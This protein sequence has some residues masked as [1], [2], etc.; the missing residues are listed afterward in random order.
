MVKG[1]VL[2]GAS[3]ISLVA[4]VVL[5]GCSDS[6]NGNG[7]GGGGLPTQATYRVTVTN[8][9]ANQPLSPLAVVIHKGGYS[10]W[11][12]GEPVSMGL[13]VLAEE[14][15]PADFIAEAGMDGSVV[16]TSSGDGAVG[17]GSSDTVEVTGTHSQDL[18]LTTAT[19]LVNTNDAFT[20]VNE[21][22]IGSLGVNESLTLYTLPFDAGTEVNSETAVTIPGPAGGG[23]GY[24]PER[25]DADFVSIHGGAVTQD[26]GL[27]ASILDE[28]HRFIGPVSKIV[29][30]RIN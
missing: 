17:P 2:K 6:S 5:T 23:E 1:Y 7:N 26:D 18:R 10:G 25:L 15:D 13:E 3:I 14:G 29:V 20:G 28:S 12:S 24:N 21:E 16:A 11:E 19:M 8:L 22:P 9:T 27:I 30:T 4:A